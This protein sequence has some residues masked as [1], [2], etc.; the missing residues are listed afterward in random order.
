M[1]VGGPEGQHNLWLSSSPTW[2]EGA[3]G[4]LVTG[5]GGRKRDT[6]RDKERHC[7]LRTAIRWPISKRSLLLSHNIKMPTVGKKSWKFIHRKIIHGEKCQPEL[8]LTASAFR[9]HFWW[10]LWVMDLALLSLSLA[11]SSSAWCLTHGD[12]LFCSSLFLL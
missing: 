12:S 3:A 8:Q 6:D 2:G 9:V 1:K 4:D 10:I 11:V 5:K 7:A